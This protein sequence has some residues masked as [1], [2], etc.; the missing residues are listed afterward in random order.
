V[1]KQ[2]KEPVATLDQMEKYIASL[3]TEGKLMEVRH[4]QE[5]EAVRK[6]AN[7]KR[8]VVRQERNNSLRKANADRKQSR[9]SAK[10]RKESQIKKARETLDQA[11]KEAQQACQQAC[12]EAL[13]VEHKRNLSTKDVFE[14]IV[15]K[16]FAHCNSAI[17]DMN[18]GFHQE[19]DV[20]L[21]KHE[22]ER[23]DL[24]ASLQEAQEALREKAA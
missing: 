4:K 2:E 15:S 8:E 12:D 19:E 24:D 16:A 23:F 20:L 14:E 10:D 6:G 21:N 7:A 22:G 17:D 9:Q 3:R 5:I 13:D 1:T 18:V 11:I